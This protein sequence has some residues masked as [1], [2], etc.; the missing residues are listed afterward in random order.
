MHLLN[1]LLNDVQHVAAIVFYLALF[2]YKESIFEKKGCLRDQ[3][4]FGV[5][6]WWRSEKVQARQMLLDKVRV[7]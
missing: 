2:A 4:P 1:N 3:G 6:E 5:Q 7:L